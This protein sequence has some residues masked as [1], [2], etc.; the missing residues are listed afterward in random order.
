MP[1]EEAIYVSSSSEGSLRQG[2]IISGLFQYFRSLENKNSVEGETLLDEVTHPWAIVLTQTCDLEQDFKARSQEA[3]EE[4]KIPS[5]LFCEVTT[6]D[7]LKGGCGGS[8]L[9]KRIKK[10]QDERYHFLQK[11]KP[12]EDSIEEGISEL[13]VD[14]KRYFTLPTEEVYHQIKGKA[15]RRAQL[16][17]PFNRH[18]ISRFFRFQLRVALPFEHLSE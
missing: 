5:I 2:E 12:Q 3:K 7:K 16:N 17:E 1:E 8:D 15:K 10:N 4:K 18:F 14:F 11:V 13:G 9:W 6:A